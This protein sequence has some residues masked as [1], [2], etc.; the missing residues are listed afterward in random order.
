MSEFLRCL[1]ISRCAVRLRVLF[2]SIKPTVVTAVWAG[3]ALW[4]RDALCTCRPRLCM[5][6]SLL[7]G[8]P[9]VA[10]TQKK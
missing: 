8:I 4:I 5:K 10:G 3:T 9:R 7:L 2:D 1:G 6:N